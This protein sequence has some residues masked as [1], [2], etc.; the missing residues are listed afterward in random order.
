MLQLEREVLN[1]M[2]P[3]SDNTG[4]AAAAFEGGITVARAIE[5]QNL[6]RPSCNPRG[7]TPGEREIIDQDREID[8]HPRVQE[9]QISKE[10]VQ[11][12]QTLRV[13]I[14]SLR[15][16]LHEFIQAGIHEPAAIGFNAQV[17]EPMALFPLKDKLFQTTVKLQD[18]LESAQELDP[19]SFQIQSFAHATQNLVDHFR[20][21]LTRAGFGMT[22]GNNDR[23]LA[24]NMLIGFRSQVTD[25]LQQYDGFMLQTFG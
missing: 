8:M 18:V 22:V 12:S 2:K 23:G 10:T 17:I 11:A 20:V 9:F 25:V 13:V 3:D 6:A 7:I 5:G 1:A 4:I 19:F 15:K 21:E 24:I 14:A 16:S